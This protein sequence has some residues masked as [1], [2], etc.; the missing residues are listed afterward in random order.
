MNIVTKKPSN[1][2][3]ITT[4]PS[5]L[6]VATDRMDS[7]ETVSLGIWAGVGTRHETAE[8]NGVAHLL[9]HMAFK[10]TRRRNALDIAQEKIGRAHV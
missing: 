7:V 10:G 2:V 9:E 8:H 3:Q 5:G 4:L 6:R 1:T